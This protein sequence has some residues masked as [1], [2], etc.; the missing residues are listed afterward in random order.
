MIE[1]VD[2]KSPTQEQKVTHI[3][4]LLGIPAHIHGYRY[5][6]E[7]I[8]MAVEDFKVVNAITKI[9]YPEIAKKHGT[10][11]SRVERAIRHAIGVFWER[12]NNEGVASIIGCCMDVGNGRPTNSEFI[13][14]VADKIRLE[15][16]AN[17]I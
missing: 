11:P 15:N 16:A 2:I 5:V 10:T 9:L 13:A 7:A 1:I 6:R 8:M 17:D 12:R 4:Q 3:L 14:T